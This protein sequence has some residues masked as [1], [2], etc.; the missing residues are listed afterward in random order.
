[1]VGLILNLHVAN[2]LPSD[3]LKLLLSKTCTWSLLR[4]AQSG[5]VVPGATFPDSYM[6]CSLSSTA[7]MSVSSSFLLPWR[8]SF[9]VSSLG[10]FKVLPLSSYPAIGCWLF[11]G[12]SENQLL[13]GTSI[14][15][16]NSHVSTNQIPNTP[17]NK[18]HKKTKQK[19]Y[20]TETMPI[21]AHSCEDLFRPC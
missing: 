9:C 14:G 19:Q 20:L 6:A 15:H 10:I 11:I 12:Q 3:I 16:V 13:A 7:F 2:A 21:F 1:M 8:F 5:E 4:W 18:Q 17:R